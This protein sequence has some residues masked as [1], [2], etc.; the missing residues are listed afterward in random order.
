MAHMLPSPLLVAATT[1]HHKGVFMTTLPRFRKIST[2]TADITTLKHLI[3]LSP[4][5]VEHFL[6]QWQE[7]EQHQQ[8]AWIL[9]PQALPHPPLHHHH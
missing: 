7:Q 5:F 6:Q 4:F 1:R 8:Q 2:A 3:I 9:L